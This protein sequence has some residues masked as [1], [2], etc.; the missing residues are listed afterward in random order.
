V[1]LNTAAK[2]LFEDMTGD[3]AKMSLKAKKE[4]ILERTFLDQAK[5]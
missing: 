4:S 1:K 5:T 2:D 3:S